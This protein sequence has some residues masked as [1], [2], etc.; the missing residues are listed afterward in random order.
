MSLD[1]HNFDHFWN[2]FFNRWQGQNRIKLVHFFLSK[3][4]HAQ[5]GNIDENVTV[6]VCLKMLHNI[7]G[8]VFI[9]KNLDKWHCDE[10]SYNGDKIFEKKVSLAV[11]WNHKIKEKV[12]KNN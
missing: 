10:Q 11:C 12:N 5:I 6:Q 8:H 9:V 4:S 7:F 1:V 3:H 2:P